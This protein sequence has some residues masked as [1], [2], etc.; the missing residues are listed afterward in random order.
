MKTSVGRLP[1]IALAVIVIVSMGC[2]TLST[3]QAIVNITASAVPILAAAGVPIPPTLP[4]YVAAVADCI[5]QA[6]VASP[7]TGQLL[8]IASCLASQVAPVVPPGMPSTVV[9]IIQAVVTDVAAFVSQ[10]QVASTHVSA[11]K[12]RPMS[13]RE[14]AAFHA[15]ASKARATA[16]AARALAKR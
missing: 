12:L 9:S 6:D 10:N 16:A 1:Y 11:M 15:A 3:L 13:G 4:L 8:T 2:S 7:T 5:G 14:A